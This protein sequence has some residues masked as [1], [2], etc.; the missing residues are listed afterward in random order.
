MIRSAVARTF[1]PERSDNQLARVVH[2]TVRKGERV[3][4]VVRPV[5]A[6]SCPIRDEADFGPLLIR[7]LRFS[8][9]HG[10]RRLP[11]RLW[12]LHDTQLFLPGRYIAVAEL[13]AE[14][15]ALLRRAGDE[16]EGTARCRSRRQ[17]CFNDRRSA[18][19]RSAC[20]TDR[21]TEADPSSCANRFCFTM[22]R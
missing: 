3:E 14:H 6:V 5:R 20:S 2:H 19:D 11:F 12:G 22:F 18:R 17:G 13:R 1:P 10:D 15:R 21:N 9:E 4:A 16:G 8:I 7:L